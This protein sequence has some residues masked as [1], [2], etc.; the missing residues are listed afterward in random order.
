MYLRRLNAEL[1]L[2]TDLQNARMGLL[3]QI[4]MF[5][6]NKFVQ[7]DGKLSYLSRTRSGGIPEVPPCLISVLKV[8]CCPEKNKLESLIAG[9]VFDNKHIHV[10]ALFCSSSQRSF[11]LVEFTRVVAQPK[12]QTYF[13]TTLTDPQSDFEK[14]M[15]KRKVPDCP[16]GGGGEVQKNFREIFE[17]VGPEEVHCSVV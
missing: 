17:S 16:D 7:E 3:G 5:F 4:D 14:E 15:Q 8:H 10:S 2:P 6:Q 11:L 12:Q 9:L 13:V 1:E